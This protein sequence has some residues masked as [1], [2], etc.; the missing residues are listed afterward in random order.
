MPIVTLKATNNDG[1]QVSTNV[2]S[3]EASFVTGEFS[4]DVDTSTFGAA[5]LAVDAEVAALLNGTVAFVL[6]GVQLMIFPIGLIITGTWLVVGVTVYGMGTFARYN[7]REA[8]RRRV[9]TVQKGGMA[10]I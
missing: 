10:R 6:P 2:S 4:S 5:Q 9:R 3:N 7:F 8:H 1:Q